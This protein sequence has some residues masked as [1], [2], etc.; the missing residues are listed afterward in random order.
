MSKYPN[1]F[2]FQGD[3]TSTFRWRKGSD[4]RDQEA[5]PHDKDNEF[6]E[7]QCRLVNTGEKHFVCRCCGQSL[8]KDLMYGFVMAA[9]YCVSCAESDPKIRRAYEESQKP[10]YYD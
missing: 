2:F 8:G 7:E 1:I 9:K 3:E 5:L 4:G 6:L 10:G